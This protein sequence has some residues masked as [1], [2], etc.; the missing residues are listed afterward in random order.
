MRVRI[1]CYADAS[2]L[3]LVVEQTSAHVDQVRSVGFSPDGTRIVSGSID[4]N[5]KF[6]GARPRLRVHVLVLARIC[7]RRRW[8]LGCSG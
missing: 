6:W 3:A 1:F 8:E 2:T 5:I 7:S 4:Q